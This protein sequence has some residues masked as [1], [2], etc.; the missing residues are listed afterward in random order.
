MGGR[1]GRRGSYGG[2][3][4]GGRGRK[5][6][7]KG[8]YG[9]NNRA[10]L[11]STGAM[12][13]TS[14]NRED[15]EK[16]D[17]MYGFRVLDDGTA[18]HTGYLINM[19][20]TTVVD[21]DGVEFSALDLFFL[22]Q[23]GSKFK[24]VVRYEPYFYVSCPERWQR[25]VTSQLEKRYAELI[26]GVEVHYM[27]D[28]DMPNHLSGKQRLF[29]KLRFRNVSELLTVRS[30]IKPIVSKNLRRNS[31][32]NDYT[33]AM[34]IGNNH[35][36]EVPQDVV[37][38]LNDIREYDVPYYTRVS[39]DND[40]RVGTWY[41]V[42]A[43]QQQVELQPLRDMVEKAEPSVLAFDIETTK[44]PLKFPN[45][46]FDQIYMISY[47][48]N[49]H[50]FLIINRSI[51][52]EDIPDF[53][54]TPKKEFK[55]PFTVWNVKDERA[56][57][58]AFFRHVRETQPQIFV[59]YNG[60]FFDWP[61]VEQRALVYG[62]SMWKEIGIKAN[63][64]GEYSGR[65]CVH[66]DCLCWVKRDSYLPSGAHGLKA[67]TKNKLGYDPV[68][69]DPE[70][71][72]RYAAEDP[73]YMSSYSV[74]DAVATYYLY[75][76][77]IHNF[78]FSLCTIIPMQADDV[79]RKGT[80][81]LCEMLLQVEAYSKSIIC[82]NKQTS[83]P[84]KYYEGHMLETETYIGGHVECLES[85]VFRSD[86][87]SHFNMVPDAFQKLIDNVDQA[88]CFA[89]EVENGLE[90]GDVLNYEEV[91][92]DIVEKL[93]LLRD[94]PVRAETP[95]VYHLDV[96]AMY[97]NIILTNRL[98]PCAM[99]DENICA[100]CDFNTKDNRNKC[101]RDMEW[102]WRG[103][104]YPLDYN[105]LK[106]IQNQL[107]TEDINGIPYFELSTDEKNEALKKRVK[108][109]CQ[110]VYRRT[111]D[112]KET[113]RTSTVCQREN[114][115][116][117]D[118]VRAF[119]D[120]RYEYKG[121]TKKWGKKLAEAEKAGNKLEM[122]QAKTRQVLYD[123]LQL[124]HKC[125]LNS[126]YGYVMRKGAR[127]HSMEMAGVVTYT[128]ATLITQARELVEQIGRPL[129]LDT[130]GIWCI[131]PASFPGN[132]T[133][134]L[135]DGKKLPI[136]YPCVMLNTDV[137]DKYT[138]HQYQ[139]LIDPANKKYKIRSECSIFFE[140][141]GPYKC[142]VLP[143]SQ[144]EGRLLKKRYAVF[145]FDGSLAELKGF[146][147]KRR[148]ELKMVKIFQQEV[149]SKFLDG[150]T[151]DECY[152]A[153]A[154]IANYWLDVLY[155]HGEDLEDD[156][157]LDLISENRN[158]SKALEEYGAQKSTAISTAKRLAEFL[159]DEMVRDKGLN[160]QMVIA[161]KP[162]GAP[163]T[164]RA[165]PT[166][167]FSAEHSIMKHFLRKWCKDSTMSDFD[168]R[169]IVDW[170]YYIQRVGSTIQKIVTV[171]AALQDVPNPVERIE[172]P[173]WLKDLVKV[174]NRKGQQ[175][176][177]S[178]FTLAGGKSNG[179]DMEDMMSPR[180]RANSNRVARVN[181][182]RKWD[183]QCNTTGQKT[184]N[185]NGATNQQEETRR[186]EPSEE[187]AP[188]AARDS[189][190]DFK[191][192]LQ[193]RKQRWRK[194]RSGI[195]TSSSNY[196]DSAAVAQYVPQWPTTRGN[197]SG[198]EGT[199][200]SAEVDNYW[201][202]VEIRPQK[203]SPGEFTLWVFTGPN[204]L[205]KKTLI[206][207]RLLYINY[208]QNRDPLAESVNKSDVAR[209]KRTKYQLPH[210]RKY[211]YLYEFE[212]LESAYIM[213]TGNSLISAAQSSPDVEGV[214]ESRVPLDL[215]AMIRSGAVSLYNPQADQ[216]VDRRYPKRRYRNKNALIH[217]KELDAASGGSDFYLST[218]STN[219]RLI[220][221]YQNTAVRGESTHGVV[222]L[223]ILNYTNRQ[224]SESVIDRIRNNDVP[225]SPEELQ[226]IGWNPF[227]D[228]V[229][230]ASA[231]ADAKSY[232]FFIRPGGQKIRM[233]D[234][235]LKRHKVSKEDLQTW[236]TLFLSSE[237]IA[238]AENLNSDIESNKTVLTDPAT[239]VDFQ[240]SEVQ[241]LSEAWI[242]VDKALNN[243]LDAS[244]DAAP[245]VLIA[246][247]LLP[248]STL[249]HAVPALDKVPIVRMEFLQ[250]DRDMLSSFVWTEAAAKIMLNRWLE[251]LYRW[252]S[253]LRSCAFTQTP[254]GNFQ[255]AETGGGVLDI[256]YARSLRHNSHLIWASPQLFPDV[257]GSEDKA[258][259]EMLHRTVLEQQDFSEDPQRENKL[260]TEASYASPL[261]I[262]QGF[263]RSICVEVH[264]DRVAL[265]AVLHSDE[266]FDQPGSVSVDT[267]VKETH[268]CSNALE[269]LKR[270]LHNWAKDADRSKSGPAYNIAAQLLE[271]FYCWLISAGS[272]L[273]DPALHRT[274]AAL[275]SRIF[276]QLASYL[277][278]FDIQV[279]MGRWDHM[280]LKIPKSNIADAQDHLSHVLE[281]VTSKS[282]FSYLRV[283]IVAWWDHLL[284]WDSANF[285][286]WRWP[287]S[288]PVF[289]DR[290]QIDRTI[291]GALPA[292][293]V[294]P[295]LDSRWNMPEYLPAMAEEAFR[296]VI[297]KFVTAA[298]SEH[299]R[300][301]NNP[302]TVLK[303]RSPASVS[304]YDDT[305]SR[306]KHAEHLSEYLGEFV[307]ETVTKDIHSYVTKLR[308]ELVDGIESFPTRLGSHLRMVHPT[309]EWIKMVCAI[310]SLEK[311]VSDQ[312]YRLKQSLLKLVHV[313]EFSAESQFVDPC[314]TAILPNVICDR[315]FTVRD[316]DLCR[317]LHVRTV[318][319]S[320]GNADHISGNEFWS[321]SRC[322]K[323]YS[324]TKFE[325]ML[326]K[327]V[328]D[329][330]VGY[331]LQDLRCSASKTPR[332]D[333]MSAT[334][335]L[336]KP[337]TTTMPKE[338]LMKL[339]RV[340]RNIAK[341]QSF[342]WLLETT[343]WLSHDFREASV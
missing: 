185:F 101:K 132:Y 253:R 53:E 318:E 46:D 69:I 78:I 80:G 235:L 113:V 282:L 283:Q 117:V 94:T 164:E 222:G 4:G 247:S 244:S 230:G 183:D 111:K 270:L 12:R 207:P 174:R 214:Y 264:L 63:S 112:T 290:F 280:I 3:S 265:N 45:A 245:S 54:Y 321:C 343:E 56:V 178:T 202:I 179:I 95:Y 232:V 239:S 8:A 317:D 60:D 189:R 300:I 256:F 2:N 322:G 138:N 131:L 89:I 296:T 34:N 233:M 175:T 21:E 171:P 226:Q 287:V 225:M 84:T 266:L 156:E 153:V 271:K 289:V 105:E 332:A 57:I 30:E 205:E 157:L 26:S 58:Q 184:L 188:S 286:G 133:L 210:D 27:D 254:I 331:Q 329:W 293:G 194:L 22:R 55:G 142:M 320:E 155:T 169:N 96:S 147:L 125:I 70:D 116:Y 87:P 149:F 176:S 243:A 67:V 126:F 76:K 303:S 68:E 47:M 19:L 118:T 216:L 103:E 272:Y 16:T 123:S 262:Q 234:N 137:H 186:A 128:G 43:V 146:E 182:F 90:R 340:F 246:Q 298:Y 38:V 338:R 336:R 316:V 200:Q 301:K 150:S 206:V 173:D 25:E 83:G 92:A 330:S 1:G 144:E 73:Q 75:M 108:E 177:I 236:K 39:I 161:R 324:R 335:Q 312:V 255:P 145:N 18:S 187:V 107:E 218:K 110:R 159:G 29:I 170:D 299:E 23:D 334:S 99:V 223:F 109:Y 50:G 327:F 10:T 162:E 180:S 308:E 192:W 13:D 201:Q 260:M 140:V 122:E 224:L 59:T 124:A 151:L 248:S 229:P 273:Y 341:H 31:A 5:S 106:A 167:I 228:V 152:Q 325:S 141:D 48:L 20:P 277:R 275:M 143:A 267:D 17:A 268:Q 215:R 326:V 104:Y 204:N 219:Y 274:V 121:L 209:M 203:S 238:M 291:D 82:P 261:V 309:L 213:R 134:Y 42:K 72:L 294:R 285:C 252:S 51:V 81:T 35:G 191:S 278:S 315:C 49:D 129:E 15:E 323:L 74:S 37:D 269:T 302:Q 284:Y 295:K 328:Q 97:P 7:G 237:P 342:D 249:F 306:S 71:M 313:E 79:L 166:A 212:C 135:K 240:I 211:K 310:L 33:A 227:E 311:A 40:V 181:M 154:N 258:L 241:S 250:K 62:M 88:L 297:T 44:P 314:L 115:F 61:F 195:G 168:I 304:E 208:T 114:P 220:Y 279:V 11:A 158:M 217:V 190:V 193:S 14:A 196:T 307:S 41:S 52:S 91:R 337:Y 276:S 257:G 197:R 281:N 333:R 130:D 259:I 86:L 36:D 199:G 339:L 172:H 319:G 127:W 98:Q 198:S 242:R 9:G 119:R 288:Q 305:A 102:I 139:E 292:N 231:P 32:T 165:I 65:A 163:V 28:L 136:S 251:S 66:M 100:S 160:C 263:H 120:R 77:Y 24:G 221:L 85:G 6:F 93:E 148:G 64:N